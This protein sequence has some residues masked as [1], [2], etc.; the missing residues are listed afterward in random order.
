MEFLVL[1]PKRNPWSCLMTRDQVI[2]PDITTGKLTVTCMTVDEV[3]IGLCLCTLCNLLLARFYRKRKT[4][5]GAAFVSVA[6]TGKQ[7]RRIANSPQHSCSNASYLV[8]I[9]VGV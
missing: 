3:P 2:Q 7:S 8:R 5:F 1:V 9:C 6:G 4:A